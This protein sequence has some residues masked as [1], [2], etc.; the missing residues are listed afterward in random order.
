MIILVII[1]L[2]FIFVIICLFH[3]KQHYN[4]NFNNNNQIHFLTFG[5]ELYTNALKRI[6]KE[7]IIFKKFNKIHKIH[8]KRPNDFDDNFKNKHIKFIESNKRGYG[9]WIWKP[10]FIQ[11]TLNIMEDND[12]LI[13]A[14]AGCTLNIKGLYRFKEY[15][16]LV[17]NSEYGII[18]FQLPYPEYQYTKMDTIESIN[19]NLNSKQLHATVIIMR[20]CPHVLNIVNQW[21]LFSENYHLIDDTPSIKPNHSEFKDHRHDQSIFSLICKKMGSIIIPDETFDF[22]NKNNK[23]FWATRKKI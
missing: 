17:K 15:I 12:I 1:L 8:I 13:Y 4:E 14:D 19:S 5:N 16:N 23:P 21:V 18:T 6:E 7:A 10:Y 3:N 20:K 9:Y 2:I 11:Q 22:D